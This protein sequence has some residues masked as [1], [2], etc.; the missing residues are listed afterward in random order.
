MRSAF[1]LAPK[2][3][4]PVRLPRLLAVLAIAASASACGGGGG[5]AFVDRSQ[6]A[7]LS[8][9][10]ACASLT[11]LSIPASDIGL[12]TSGAT[13]SS[14]TVVPAVG[15]TTTTTSVRHATP[16]YCKVLGDILPV[17]PTALNIK[18]Q[19]NVPTVW[20][21][22]S[23]QVG[24]GGLDGNLPANLATVTSSGSPI[25]SA[26]PPDAPYPISKG[27]ASFG[28]DSGHQDPGTTATWALNS[29]AWTNFG[30]AGLKKTH[31]AAFAVLQALYGSKPQV[32]YFMGQSQGGREAMEV[33]QRY[34]DDYDGIVATSPLIGYSAHV[35]H[36][37][38]L[39]TVQTGGGWIP[40]TKLATIGAEVM[41]QCDALDGV[42]DGIVSNYRACTALFDPQ[43]VAKPFEMIRCAGGA[44]TGTSCLSDAQIATINQMHAPTSF[45]FDLANG[46]SSFPGYGT[47]REGLSGWLNINPQPNGASQ[48]SLGQPGATV[49]Y[50]ILKDPSFNLVNFSI[51]AF[52]DKIQAASN[53][54]DST[55]PDLSRFFARG[56]RM[57]V[58]NNGSDY[59]SNPQIMMRYYDTVVAKL[60]QAA[61][62]AHVRY[63]ILPNTNHGGD[64]VSTTTG[65]AIPQYVD[66]ITMSTDWVEKNVTPPD[67]PVVSAK[68]AVPPY[69][70]NAT[71]PMCRY[72]LYPRYNGTG[73]LK[74]AANFVCTD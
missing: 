15:E 33:A 41:R 42:I 23:I 39:A 51:A 34:P 65:E 8:P 14:A 27:Y 24:G 59:N 43:K 21:Q 40:T 9:K 46:L 36:K 6:L 18:F 53:L 17:D 32:S 54:I 45:G 55:N 31:D 22:K 29:E 69:Q 19:L 74:Q 37:T 13:I 67:A 16:E 25:S 10:V 70:V 5:D 2:P 73:D 4:Y 38:L 35:I 60:G 11:G 66:L 57:I 62:D 3:L 20:N 49:M 48:P 68:G 44:D 1:T 47:G 50:G 58:K 71:R 28:G 30:H 26:F 7:Q 64:G 61:V 52:K 12:P 63:Y 56:G 72:P